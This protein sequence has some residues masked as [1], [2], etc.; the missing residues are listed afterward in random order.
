MKKQLI[1]LAILSTISMASLAHDYQ[2]GDILVRGGI[3]NITPDSEQHTIYAAGQTVNLGAGAIS[4]SVEDNTQLSLNLVYFFNAN[5]AI[6]VL[7]ATPYSHD[8]T[9]HTGAGNVNL[10][11]N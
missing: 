10:G 2:A 11:E 1:S 9:V 3:T 6:E 4:A 7:A 5:W 8:I